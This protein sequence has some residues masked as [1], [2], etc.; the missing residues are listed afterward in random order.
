[1]Q[2]EISVITK[3]GLGNQL[4]QLAFS[5]FLVQSGNTVVIN[6][7][8]FQKASYHD[9]F[10]LNELLDFQILNLRQSSEEKT[11]IFFKLLKGYNNNL[12]LRGIF[13]LKKLWIIINTLLGRIP[14]INISE[15]DYLLIRFISQY[16]GRNPFFDSRYT[17]YLDGYWQNIIYTQ[18]SRNLIKESILDLPSSSKARIIHQ[19]IKTSNSVAIHF[20]GGDFKSIEQ[21]NILTQEYYKKAL[22][23]ILSNTINP[24][25]FLFY[26]DKQ[27]MKDM[28]PSHLE[29]VVDVSTNDFKSTEDF[30]LMKSCSRLIISNSSFSWWAAYLTDSDFVV[31]PSRYGWELKKSN[32]V[33]SEWK[34]IEV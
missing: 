2:R 18:S 13:T 11:D 25:F 21:Y 9:G 19:N 33:D 4:F 32:L 16:F 14:K 1:M 23:L 27:F 34:I 29:N 26:D 7:S 12:W 22:E 20:R 6:N 3:G 10:V 30:L 17:F 5:L 8:L 24:T 31:S 28:L 15:K